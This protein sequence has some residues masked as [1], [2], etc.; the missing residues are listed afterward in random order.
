MT[1]EEVEDNFRNLILEGQ[2]GQL[3]EYFKD[4]ISEDNPPLDFKSPLRLKSD[5]EDEATKEAEPPEENGEENNE[6]GEDGEEEAAGEEAGGNEETRE[7]N[8][9]ENAEEAPEQSDN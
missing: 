5:P 9:E 7:T 4:K 2:Y 3:V 8:G 1:D 6:E